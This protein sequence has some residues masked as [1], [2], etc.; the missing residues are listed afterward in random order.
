MSR[1][2]G[3]AQMR[4]V[5][6]HAAVLKRGG[7]G[8]MPAAQSMHPTQQQAVLLPVYTQRG[9]HAPP[10]CVKRALASPAALAALRGRM[11]TLGTKRKST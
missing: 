4:Y 7:S 6:E 9:G 11:N 10:M 1:M 3:A 5:A 8:C 2:H